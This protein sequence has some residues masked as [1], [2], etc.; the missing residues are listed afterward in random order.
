MLMNSF[1]GGLCVIGIILSSTVSYADTRVVGGLVPIRASSISN[2]VVAVV[3]NVGVNIGDVVEEGDVL[4]ALDRKQYELQHNLA[5]SE[6]D[7]STAEFNASKRQLVRIKDLYQKSNASVSQL[8]E[9]QRLFEVSRA[10]LKVATA[11]LDLSKNILKKTIINAPFDAW[12]GAR[13]IEKGQLL[14]T[15]TL[16][17]ELVDIS[18][19]KVVF[20]LLENDLK[21]IDKFDFV[22]VSIPVLDE[23]TFNAKV[24]HIAPQ[25]SA[26]HPGYRVEAIIDNSDLK[27]RPGF[28]ARIRLSDAEQKLVGE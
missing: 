8:D 13:Y 10:Q 1:K 24:E 9:S 19:L 3:D 11:R 22:K 12:I 20:Y 6:V 5:Q 4:A 2:E 17:F 25:Q 16:M 21:L 18:K 15:S 28:T 27:L 23:L 7:L 26:I 14:N